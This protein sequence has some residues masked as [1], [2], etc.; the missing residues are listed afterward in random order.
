MRVPLDLV[1]H[2]EKDEIKFGLKTKEFVAAK[3][4]IAIETPHHLHEFE[5]IRKHSIA[6]SLVELPPPDEL[7][8]I[9][10]EFLDGVLAGDEAERKSQ[11]V[12]Q[13]HRIGIEVLEEPARPVYAGDGRY[14][15]SRRWI[16]QMAHNFAESLNLKV[17][18]ESDADLIYA[19]VR[20]SIRAVEAI[21]DRDKHGSTKFSSSPSACYKHAQYFK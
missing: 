20:A 9:A 8:L 15:G 17:A 16:A 12:S 11:R 19:V 10:D 2:Y 21:D 1:D 5:E 7:K 3:R 13:G 18:S 4:K 14:D 6:D